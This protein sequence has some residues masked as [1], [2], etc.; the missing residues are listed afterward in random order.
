MDGL[1]YSRK[2]KVPLF[3][4]RYD[5]EGHKVA[6]YAFKGCTEPIEIPILIAFLFNAVRE[7]PGKMIYSPKEHIPLGVAVHNQGEIY[8]IE[9]KSG[10]KK[11]IIRLSTY[12]T[13]LIE[14]EALKAS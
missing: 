11:D 8:S 2:E 6:E 5:T 7:N 1:V 13:L 9:V 10:R 4:L 3:V 12:F 14:S